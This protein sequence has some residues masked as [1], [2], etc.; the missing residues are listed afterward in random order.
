VLIFLT[1]IALLP[2]WDFFYSAQGVC[3][4]LP[5]QPVGMQEWA[6]LFYYAEGIIPAKALGW[7]GILTAA[8]FTVGFQTRA[9]TIFLFLLV[10][11]MVNTCR[12]SINGEDLVYRMLLFYSCF[13]P[14]G[15]S[16]SVDS[17]RRRGDASPPPRIWPVRLMQINFALIY[18]FTQTRKVYGDPVWMGGDAMYY[19]MVNTTWSR[20]PWPMLFANPLVTKLTTYGSLVIELAFPLLVWFRPFRLSVIALLAAVHIGIAVGLQNVT[21]FSLAMVAAL[22]IFVPA[23]DTRRLGRSVSRWLSLRGTPRT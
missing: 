12:S 18:I 14:L 4:R 16:L 3:K 11:S 10:C 17:W 8:S 15:Q 23:A 13:A 5:G 19:T 2:S 6:S 1:L 9:C 20:F 7:L 21:F 22:W